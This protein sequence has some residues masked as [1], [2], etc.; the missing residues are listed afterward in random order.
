[1]RKFRDHIKCYESMWS[2]I[3]DLALT[4]KLNASVG[5]SLVS[6]FRS[7][8]SCCSQLRR[9]KTEMAIS[10]QRA[11]DE[12]RK[13]PWSDIKRAECNLVHQFA[14]KIVQFESDLCWASSRDAV[15]ICRMDRSLFL[16]LIFFCYLSSGN[17]CRCSHSNEGWKNKSNSWKRK[18]NQAECLSHC[19]KIDSINSRRRRTPLKKC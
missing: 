10:H 5:I 15:N 13:S 16:S 19:P 7:P 12:L 3:F 2:T 18:N 6:L 1:M 14:W 9:H 4:V 8:R 11:D 17:D